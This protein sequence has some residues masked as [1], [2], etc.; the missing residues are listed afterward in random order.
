MKEYGKPLTIKVECIPT[1]EVAQIFDVVKTQL[2]AVGIKVDYKE[3]DQGA[4]VGR[5]FGKVGDYEIGCFRTNQF[6]EPDQVRSGY[7][8]EDKNNLIFYSNPDVDKL[9]NEGKATADFAK[10]K[11]AYDKIQTILVTDIPGIV[12]IYDL[13]GN[14]SSQN[15]FGVPNPEASALG[16]IKLATVFIKK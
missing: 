14:I 2:E 6:I 7:A 4:Y 10:R 1:P 13:A 5:I 15:V 12:L 8:T 16:A 11:A 9:F 3:Q